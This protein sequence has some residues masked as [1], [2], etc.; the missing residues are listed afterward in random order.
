MNKFPAIIIWFSLWLIV[1]LITIFTRPYLPV[2]ET[3]YISVAWEMWQRGQWLVPHLNGEIYAHKPPLLFWLIQLSWAIFGVNEWAPRLVTSL[4]T[5]GNLGLT[6]YLARLL[7]HSQPLISQWVPLIL[8]SCLLWLFFTPALMFDMLTVFFTLMGMVALILAWRG[9]RWAWGLLG[10]AFGLGILS[11]GPVIFLHLLPIA[12]L[13]PLW[14]NETNLSKKAVLTHFSQQKQFYK[15]WY[16]GIFT[17]ILIGAL[18][19]LAW[20]I[21]AGI[22]GGEEYRAAIFWKQTAGRMVQSFAHQ[23]PM[24]WY[25]LYLPLGLFP[26]L[27]WLPTWRYLVKL[28]NFLHDQGVRFCLTWFISVLVAFSLI[29]GKQMHYLLPIYPA[30]ALLLTYLLF[31]LPIQYKRWDNSLPSLFIFLMGILLL[32]LP[33]FTYL[34]ARFSTWLENISP[35][36]GVGLI[37]ISI[38][39]VVKQ[40]YS[41][42]PILQIIKLS[43]LSSLA[44]LLLSI[45]VL[46]ATEGA[47]HLQEIGEKIAEAQIAGKTVAHVGEYHGQYQF[48]GRL[49]QSLV[50]LQEEENFCAWIKQNPNSEMIVYF[51][52]KNLQEIQ[53]FEYK[54]AYRGQ[55][56]GLI[57]SQ[58]LLT[59]CY[60]L[61]PLF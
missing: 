42:S 27:L 9:H 30:F 41:K 31:N 59:A 35:L 16:L 22:V 49:Q 44:C 29:S 10:I 18:I 37:I 7:W 5:L 14:Q 47:Y 39:L 1:L 25:L 53:L 28:P 57:K 11:K 46:H 61:L 43:I 15:L 21:P 6:A 8:T 13:A 19:A 3:R 54:Q 20:A 55:W 58:Y 38:I 52:D 26:W 4:F 36:Y 51:R 17:S 34:F 60:P 32:L 50:I 12:L 40:Q 48:P 45:G 33:N 2:D 56:V 24:W 23:R